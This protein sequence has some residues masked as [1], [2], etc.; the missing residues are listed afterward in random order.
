MKTPEKLAQISRFH[1]LGQFRLHPQDFHKVP[2]G[3]HSPGFL[4]SCCCKLAL[5][6]NPWPPLSPL[7]AGSICITEGVEREVEG[8]LPPQKFTRKLWPCS[9]SVCFQPL[10][11]QGPGA[12]HTALPAGRP[13]GAVLPSP[14]HG[15]TQCP[16]SLAF[17]YN[18][19]A[20]ATCP[21]PPI[22]FIIDIMAPY[23]D[24]ESYLVKRNSGASH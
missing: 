19:S 1:N 5:S 17:L 9:S 20:P 21:L 18:T 13:R 10:Q 14:A 6:L 24:K 15:P 23:P 16:F 4:A 8:V 7:R 11:L 3:P 2:K 12:L 22:T